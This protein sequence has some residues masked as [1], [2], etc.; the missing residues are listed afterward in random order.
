MTSA[1]ATPR[2]T[3]TSTQSALI[4]IHMLPHILA[5]THGLTSFI[6]AICLLGAKVR[7]GRR[8]DSKKTV[9]GENK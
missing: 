2:Q 5:Y 1:K 3:K 4:H 9:S 8:D 7:G 6:P